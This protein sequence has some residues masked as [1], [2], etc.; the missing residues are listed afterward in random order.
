VSTRFLLDANLSP[1]VG[2]VLRAKLGLD[3]ISLLEEERG[4][5]RDSDIVSFA[6]TT[7][8]VIITQDRDFLSYFHGPRRPDISVIYLNLPNRLRT[9]FGIN[10]VLEKYFADHSDQVIY[11]DVQV[12]ITEW[13]VQIQYFWHLPG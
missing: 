8:R 2:V 9:I 6:R 4:H 10:Q 5:I 1:R 13:N 7:D 11:R 12:T 3:L